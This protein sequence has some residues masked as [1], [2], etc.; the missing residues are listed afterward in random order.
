MDR[1]LRALDLIGRIYDAAAEPA[2]WQNFVDGLSEALDGS[3]VALSFDLPALPRADRRFVAGIGA[4]VGSDCVE[5]F[6]EEV[7]QARAARHPFERGFALA[8]LSADHSIESSAFCESWREPRKLAPAWPMGHLIAS[9]DGRPIASIV[10]YRKQGS[11]AF[12]ESDLAFANR[13]VSCPPA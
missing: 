12:S 13:L 2:L 5:T 9:E 3:A 8:H 6:L 4:D 10:A 7:P 1:N 11:G